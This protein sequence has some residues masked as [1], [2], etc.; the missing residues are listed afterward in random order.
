MRKAAAL[1]RRQLRQE[2]RTRLRRN[3]VPAWT[4]D[5]FDLGGDDFD[6]VGDDFDLVGDDRWSSR[7]TA[8][9]V[10]TNGRDPPR[11]AS[12]ASALS[13]CSARPATRR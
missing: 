8:R 5:D 3:N 4:G 10:T 2:H 7:F 9:S 1:L 12:A 13:R 11:R 6:L